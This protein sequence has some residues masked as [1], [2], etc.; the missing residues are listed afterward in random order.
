MGSVVS[1]AGLSPNTGFPMPVPP[2]IHICVSLQSGSVGTFEPAIQ[3]PNPFIQVKEFRG[4]HGSM[5]VKALY[6][7]SEGR[8]FSRKWCHWN[9]LL[10]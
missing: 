2:L 7:K 5:V 9:F 1:G 6:Y 4:D 10:T 3:S 8:W